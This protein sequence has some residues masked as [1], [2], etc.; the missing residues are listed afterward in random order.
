MDRSKTRHRG[1]GALCERQALREV[2]GRRGADE[3]A[4]IGRHGRET[5]G[6]GPDGPPDRGQGDD[7]DGQGGDP[8]QVQL[9]DVGAQ[10]AVRVPHCADTLNGRSSAAGDGVARPASS[11]MDRGRPHARR[12]RGGENRRAVRPAAL[13]SLQPSMRESGRGSLREPVPPA[14][15][16][17]PGLGE[18]KTSCRVFRRHPTTPCHGRSW[19]VRQISSS[20]KPGRHLLLEGTDQVCAV[21]GAHT[22][23]EGPTEA[24]AAGTLRWGL[25][26]ARGSGEPR[27][28]PVGRRTR[29]SAPRWPCIPNGTQTSA[30]KL[31][32]S[33][34]A[35]INRAESHNAAHHHR[36]CSSAWIRS[37]GQ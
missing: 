17:E 6:G 3:D 22:R 12:D 1:P 34:A 18:S 24:A 20:P 4:E 28:S 8:H 13:L 11:D 35:A 30:L 26:S 21:P 29:S 14:T 23:V 37:H 27:P 5:T 32:G 9:P 33:E 16:G 19:K 2:G 7:Q 15:P 36:H 31:I 10:A 25:Q